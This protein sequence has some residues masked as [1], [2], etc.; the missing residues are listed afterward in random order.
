MRAYF[1]DSASGGW[2]VRLGPTE[3]PVALLLTLFVA[4]NQAFFM[5]FFFLI[6]GYFTP[7]S[8]DLRGWAGYTRERLLRLGLPVLAFGFV[9]GPLTV[10]IA[11]NGWDFVRP[12]L[13]RMSILDFVIGPMWFALALLMFSLGY[14]VRRRFFPTPSRKRQPIPDHGTWIAAALGVGLASL[15]VRQIMPVGS[16][17]LGFQLGYFPSYI[18]LFATGLIAERYGWL[19]K[20]RRQH[21]MPWLIAAAVAIPLLPVAMIV[22]E[23]LGQTTF[24]TGFSLPS[25]F[26]AFWEPV[27]AWGAI[28]GALWWFRRHWAEPNKRWTYLS[29]QSYGAF[30]LHPPVLVSTALMLEAL[31]APAFI[32]FVMLILIGTVVSF[33]LAAAVRRM[34]IVRRVI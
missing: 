33:G 1:I 19:E 5:G 25:V 30:I 20:V 13:D 22:G 31:P 14:V 7:I 17:F 18:F 34:R 21:A 29:R 26:Y 12:W 27:V 3:G 16:E 11:G 23:A 15:V 8:Y 10:A 9:I 28:A 24:A 6:S 32:K 2:F 4:V